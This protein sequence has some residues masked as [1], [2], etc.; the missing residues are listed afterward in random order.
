MFRLILPCIVLLFCSCPLQFVYPQTENLGEVVPAGETEARFQDKAV[1]VK[2]D[3]KE[4][5]II[6]SRN[7]SKKMEFLKARGG[8]AKSEAAVT[9][10]I[11]FLLRVQQPDGSWHLDDRR[12]GKEIGIKNHVAGTA[13]GLLPL[14]ATGATHKL[15]KM[16]GGADGAADFERDIAKAI[17]KGVMFLLFSQD[18]K[19]GAFDGRNMYANAIATIAMCELYAMSQDPKLRRSAQ[20]A[21]DFIVAAQ[22]DEGGWRY[23]PKM[24]GDTSATGWHLMALK[25]AVWAGLDVPQSCFKKASRFLDSVCD[26]KTTEGY[27]YADPRPTPTL[28]AVG[29]LCRQ[30]VQGWSIKNPRMNKGWNYLRKNPPTADDLYFTYY[31]TQVMYHVGGDEWTEW[32]NKMQASLIAAQDKSMG[33][34]HGSFPCPKSTDKGGH[35]SGR[36]MQTSLSLLS[37]QIYYRYPPRHALAAVKD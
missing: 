15:R 36:L 6:S 21:V 13:F 12:F 31:A 5:G 35:V 19:T 27:G 8:T 10:G 22:H 18:G 14:L 2:P 29:L 20:Q 17:D 16:A 26:F 25:T 34:L 9:R 32:N 24:Q 4:I 11:H 23:T 1:L 3:A 30:N 33:D 28:T 7:A 37:L